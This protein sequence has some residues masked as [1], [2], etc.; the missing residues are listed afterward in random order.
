MPRAPRPPS[1]G[2]DTGRQPIR[3]QA[4]KTHRQHDRR[5]RPPRPQ[6]FSPPAAPNRRVNSSRTPRRQAEAG[7]PQTVAHRQRRGRL[8]SGDVSLQGNRFENLG[9]RFRRGGAQRV[10]R[11]IVGL[12]LR[13][14]F[15]FDAGDV[16]FD[17]AVDVLL[18]TNRGRRNDFRRPRAQSTPLFCGYSIDTRMRRAR[19]PPDAVRPRRP[20]RRR[21][22]PS[23]RRARRL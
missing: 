8:N 16:G 22:R 21:P 6:G 11:G 10:S 9:A 3:A 15:G 5:R 18:R 13:E 17:F 20:R 12:P 14:H 23:G 19:C 7:R 4:R 2:R 1:A